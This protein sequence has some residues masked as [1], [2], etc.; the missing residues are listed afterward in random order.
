MAIERVKLRVVNKLLSSGFN[1]EKAIGAIGIKELVSLKLT[2]DETE[3]LF[4][5]QNAIKKNHVIGYLSGD[6]EQA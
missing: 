2:P 5:L 1:D 3:V 6:E 4:D